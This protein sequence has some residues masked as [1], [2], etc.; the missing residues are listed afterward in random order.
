MS[1]SLFVLCRELGRQCVSRN[2]HI[3]F[4]E[5][6]TGGAVASVI[7]ETSGSSAWFNGSAVVY[8]NFSKTQL[9]NVS[10]ELIQIH[11][12]VSESVAMA[13]AHGALEKFQAD[14]AIAITGIA[15]PLGGTKEKPVGM[16][17]FALATKKN[18][19]TMAKTA[20][21]TSG[22]EYIRRSATEFVLQWLIEDIQ[23]KSHEG[24][25]T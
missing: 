17:C 4:A 9:L 13:M 21:F 11:G 3:A 15:G 12:A 18:N 2:L 25:Q 20:Y 6:C 14:L 1:D 5:S 24:T 22:R 19:T 7:T 16:I 8:S 10:P 23:G